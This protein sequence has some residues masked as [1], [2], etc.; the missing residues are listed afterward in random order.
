MRARDKAQIRTK[1]LE[2][3]AVSVRNPSLAMI[4]ALVLSACATPQ[5]Q[6]VTASTVT[7]VDDKFEPHRH[8]RTGEIKTASIETSGYETYEK[9]LMAD[10]DRKT[11]GIGA[12]LQYTITYTGIQRKYHEAR[13]VRAEQLSVRS[14]LHHASGCNKYAG[15]LHTEAVLIDLPVS[16]LRNAGNQG[17]P[18]K[19]F[20]KIGKGIEIEIPKTLI[21]SLLA[22]LD[23]GEQ[24][25][26]AAQQ[27]P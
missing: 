5:Q 18:I 27:K 20:P 7:I 17:Y 6:L 8:Y 4:C 3:C 21:V 12:G 11:G 19:L 24:R 22:A 9:K 26:A 14:V 10:V 2:W 25:T 23:A 15:C 13:N 1:S 16:E